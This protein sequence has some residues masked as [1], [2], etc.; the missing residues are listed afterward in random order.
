MQIEKENSCLNSSGRFSATKNLNALHLGTEIIFE[1]LP[2]LNHQEFSVDTDS[3]NHKNHRKSKSR[4][5]VFG[6]SFPLADSEDESEENSKG[7]NY[8]ESFYTFFSKTLTS[9]NL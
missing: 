5:T 9:R 4:H 6:S 8:S 2:E 3:R 1:N 7:K